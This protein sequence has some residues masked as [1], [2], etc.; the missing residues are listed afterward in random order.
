M[1]LIIFDCDGVLVDS[2]TL[3]NEISAQC[4]TE[5]GFAITGPEARARFIGLTTKAVLAIVESEL[6]RKLPPDWEEV[7]HARSHAALAT[8]VE[9]IEGVAAAI[10][11]LE[12]MGFETAVASSGEHAKMKITL[13]RTG[14]YERFKGRIFSAQDVAQGKPAPDVY[15]LAAKTLGYA[16]ETCF[17]VEDSPNGARAAI[18]AGMYTFGYGAQIDPALLM[19][20]N[21]NEIFLNMSELPALLKQAVDRNAVIAD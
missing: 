19:E 5:A 4:L 11:A 16:P 17:A 9:A 15:L 12:A 18:A 14:L 6:G 7:Y 8:Q 1:P 13:G 3:E 21:V 10:D 20:A 2:E